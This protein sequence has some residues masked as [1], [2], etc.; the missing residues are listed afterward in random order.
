VVGVHSV[1]ADPIGAIAVKDN[2]ISLEGGFMQKPRVLVWVLSVAVLLFVA[3]IAHGQNYPDRTVRIVTGGAGGGNDIIARLIAQGLS[4][5]FGQQ[6][7]VDNRASGIIP[8]EVVSKAPP[9]GYTVVLSGRSFWL[10]PFYLTGK[11]PYDPVKDFSPITIP[12]STPN[13]LAV[14]PQLPVTSVK[15]LIAL[16]KARPGELNYGSPGTGSSP[17]LAA[18]VFKS[19]AGVDI[20][21]VNYKGAAPVYIDLMAGQIQMTFGSA[22]SVSPHIVSGKLKALAVTSAKPSALAPGVP[23]VAASGLPGYEFVSPFGI[24]A[25]ARTPA[26]IVSKLN[27]EIVK[28]L[29][30]PDVKEKLFNSRIGEVVGSS[31]EE[32]VAMVKADMSR[33]GKIIKESGV[34]SR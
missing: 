13:I 23:T 27:S 25:P 17:H 6:V 29:N 8:G 31:P 2:N 30:K 19:M 15:D 20:V 22:T 3:G 21:R 18:E 5:S 1:V 33:L 32:L 10:S 24:F 16:A 14:H 11:W 4:V 9:D 7:I 34:R 26:P 28:V 12:V